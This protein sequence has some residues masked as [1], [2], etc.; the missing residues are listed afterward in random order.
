MVSDPGAYD[1]CAAAYAEQVAWRERAGVAGDPLGIAPRLL[2]LLGD[3]SGRTVL[4]AGCGEGYL[5]RILAARG[6]RVVGIDVSPRLI[7]LARARDPEGVIEYRVADLSGPLPECAGRFDAVASFLVLND[8]ADYHGFVA[9]LAAVLKPA[10]RLVV[11]LNNPYSYVVR[12]HLPDY[13]DSGAARPYRGMA[14]GGAGVHFYQRTLEAYLDAF[15]AAGLRLTKL[16][17][18]DTVVNSAHMDTLLPEGYRFPYF[19]LL[20]LVKP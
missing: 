6:A 16:V 12:K 5:A 13:F 7:A 4:D 1:D 15:L 8:V 2:E 3:L 20:R 19:M 14:A 18:L 17:D 9:T 10:G 11:A